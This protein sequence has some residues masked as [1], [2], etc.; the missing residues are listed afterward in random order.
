MPVLA[1]VCNSFHF[2][3]M[4]I[5]AWL[6]SALTA[7]VAVSA[8]AQTTEQ[9][10]PE[11]KKALPRIVIPSDKP[12]T[13]TQPQTVPAIKA[14]NTAAPT[15][16]AQPTVA[17]PKT[18]APKVT[19]KKKEDEMGKI[20]GVEVS[21]GD[22]GYFGVQVVG[23]SF[24]LTFY[25]DK[26]KPTAGGFDRAALRWNPINKKGDERVVLLPDGAGQVFTA[27]A[28]VKPPYNFKL[29][30]TLVKEATTDGQPAVTENYVVDFRQ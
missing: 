5:P 3:R 18:P 26:K 23:T 11:K 1:G 29:F 16:A 6:V 27:G 14:T 25:N 7:A 8:S 24:R 4:K 22:K 13:T 28:P 15:T 9:T 17:A 2:A 30:V 19:P 20:E 10:A 21:R 12:A